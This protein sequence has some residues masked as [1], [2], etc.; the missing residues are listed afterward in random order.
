MP[1]FDFASDD[2]RRL[3]KALQPLAIGDYPRAAKLGLRIVHRTK[4]GERLLFEFELRSDTF[5]VL[6]RVDDRYAVEHVRSGSVRISQGVHSRSVASAPARR[7]TSVASRIAGPRRSH[8]REEWA[9]VL[10]GDPAAGVTLASRRQFVLALGFLV[11]AVRMRARDVAVP[12]WRPVDW[13]L[14]VG[15]RTEGFI[16]VPPGLLVIYIAHHD[17]LH[18]LLTEGW[19]WVGACGVATYWFTRWLRRL[20]GVELASR[21]TSDGE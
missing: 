10:A 15:R 19:G 4:G 12:F 13:M 5:L 6:S 11:A 16:A 18:V 1:N 20:R 7:A 8:L 3:R 9:A 14:S 2:L 21:A 17:G